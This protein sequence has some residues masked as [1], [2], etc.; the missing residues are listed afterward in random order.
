MLGGPIAA[1]ILVVGGIFCS[2]AEA[3]W[4]VPDLDRTPVRGSPAATTPGVNPVLQPSLRTVYR[5]QV[6]ASRTWNRARQALRELQQ[7]HPKLLGNLPLEVERADLSSKGIWYRMQIGAF[8]KS[9]EA[10]GFCRELSQIGVSDCLVVKRRSGRRS[11]SPIEQ[12][13]D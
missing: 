12:H 7:A 1:G 6:G 9:S 5:V 3:G 11:I 10:E 8:A 2:A 4:P 13:I